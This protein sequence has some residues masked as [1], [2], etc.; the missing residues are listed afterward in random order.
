MKEAQLVLMA[1]SNRAW[2]QI[3]TLV[4]QAFEYQ[5]DEAQKLMEKYQPPFLDQMSLDLVLEHLDPVV[6]LNNFEYLNKKIRLREVMKSK[7]LTYWR[8]FYGW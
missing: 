7:P 1:N 2:E 4:F 5:P 8:K 6:G 3:Q